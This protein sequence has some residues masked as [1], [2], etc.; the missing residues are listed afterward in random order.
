MS[1]NK[2]FMAGSFAVVAFAQTATLTPQ[3]VLKEIDGK[4]AKAVVEEKFEPDEKKWDQLLDKID[5]GTDAWLKVAKK[6]APGTDAATALGLK[7]S[8]AVALTHNPEGVLRM[9]PFSAFTLE[10]VCTVPFIES[11]RAKDIAHIQKVRLALKRV[12]SPD[13]KEKRDK[14]QEFIEKDAK[15]EKSRKG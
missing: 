9:V 13:L 10:D 14:C 7:I 2:L 15:A 5:T 8:L 12:T 1:F 4:G 6:I 11:S 3:G